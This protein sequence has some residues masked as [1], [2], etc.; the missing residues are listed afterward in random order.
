MKQT[1][2][3]SEFSGPSKFTQLY[4]NGLFS[5]CG[6]STLMDMVNGLNYIIYILHE[7][8]VLHILKYFIFA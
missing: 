3:E 5:V 2:Y 7:A 6:Q 4:P 1:K 8:T